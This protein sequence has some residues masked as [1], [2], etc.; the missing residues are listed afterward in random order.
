MV[1]VLRGLN[2]NGIWAGPPAVAFCSLLVLYWARRGGGVGKLWNF[3][4]KHWKLGVG[5]CLDLRIYLD[6]LGHGFSVE[7]MP[8]VLSS[9][10]Y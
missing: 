9:E 2:K 1:G 5:R 8:V 6:T 10:Q 7:T 3:W 4:G